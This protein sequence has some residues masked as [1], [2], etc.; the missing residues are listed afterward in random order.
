MYRTSECQFALLY[1]CRQKECYDLWTI[2]DL[3]SWWSPAW[4]SWVSCEC[5][6]QWWSRQWRQSHAG[7]WTELPAMWLIPTCSAVPSAPAPLPE[8][9]SSSP[10]SSSFSSWWTEVPATWPV[11]ACPAVPSAP[12]LLLGYT[13]S[14]PLSSSS[15]LRGMPY[16]QHQ[17][18]QLFF[19]LL[20]QNSDGS[21]KAAGRQNRR[22]TRHSYI[23][24]FTSHLHK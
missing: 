15:E 6:G 3:T 10:L 8:C 16:D 17:H 7:W 4:R 23:N 14:S 5:Q 24:T 18:P 21:V 2:S 1:P 13:S 22:D 20:H 19:Q 11:L 12:A 9:T